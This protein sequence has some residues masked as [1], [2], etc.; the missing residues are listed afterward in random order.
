MNLTEHQRIGAAASTMH[1]Q[2]ARRP[3][4]TFTV[5]VAG[6]ILRRRL[7]QFVSRG[8]PSG[9]LRRIK[10][11]TA[12]ESKSVVASSLGQTHDMGCRGVSRTERDNFVPACPESRRLFPPSEIPHHTDLETW[13]KSIT[14]RSVL[15]IKGTQRSQRKYDSNNGSFLR[16]LCVYFASFA[17][18][19]FGVDFSVASLELLKCPIPPALL[20]PRQKSQRAFQTG[21]RMGDPSRMLLI[22]RPVRFTKTHDE[23]KVYM[24]FD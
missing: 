11:A 13:A 7:P 5:N 20:Y 17:V 24:R 15:R 3:S 14:T 6:T 16:G 12:A 22:S 21:K 9:F 1:L 2:K 19:S 4:T 18:Q 8:T 10:G 23:R